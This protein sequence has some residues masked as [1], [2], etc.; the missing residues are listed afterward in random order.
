M[1]AATD[2]EIA[3]LGAGFSG[4]A[5]ATALLRQGVAPLRLALID[6][7]PDTGRGRAY[8]EPSGR[9][10]LNVP[11]ARMSL[12]T[13]APDDFLNWWAAD[14]GRPVAVLAHDFAPRSDYGRYVAARFAQTLADSNAQLSRI[15]HAAVDIKA[16]DGDFALTLDDGRVLTARQIVLAFG[17]A[18]GPP[19]RA[20][21]EAGLGPRLIDPLAPGA[22]A[23]LHRDAALALIGT[24]LT[25]VD[26][27]SQLR[28]HG[29]RG[30][31]DC[32]SRH[33]RWPQAHRAPGP[34]LAHPLS[35]AELAR[36]PRS[37]LRC[38]RE[39]ERAHRAQGGDWRAVIDALRPL[40]VATWQAWPARAKAQA[41]RHLRSLWDVHRH[42]MA[43]QAAQTLGAALADPQVH[44]HAAQLH[45][46]RAVAGERI[47]LTLKPRAGGAIRHLVVDH[48]LSALGPVVTLGARSDP[49]ARALLARGLAR[50]DGAGL[51]LDV[52]S[53]GE[54]IDAQGQ[55]HAALYAIGPLLRARDWETI[56]VPEIRDQAPV[57]A[58][59]LLGVG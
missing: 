1:G 46:A 38:V 49:L 17:Y 39:A 8:H 30:R 4:T 9:L 13:D 20:I 15:A 10:L 11:A 53:H 52:G 35:A 14:C 47:E 36:S 2:F 44:V 42:R 22:L 37:A 40:T 28:A 58:A 27:I 16:R 12:L 23:A 41:L 6:P 51:G 19:L 43:P 59:R 56:A 45:R 57:L 3:I 31:I 48:L 33:G 21:A 50:D 7:S 54:L 24:G 32:I 26:A 5:L 55:P 18:P 34:T 25:A 29:H